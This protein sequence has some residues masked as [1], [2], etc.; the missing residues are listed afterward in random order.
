MEKIE[1]KWQIFYK[2]FAEKLSRPIKS[3]EFVIYF[4]IVILIVGALGIH[5][6]WM[7]DVF[8]TT[9]DGYIISNMTCYFLTLVATSSL[10]LFLMSH[11]IMTKTIR[12][13]SFGIVV[14]SVILFFFATKNE[15]YLLASIGI[16]ISLLTWWI[17]NADNQ[18]IIDDSYYGKVRESSNKLTKN[19]SE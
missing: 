11:D 14:I 12:I 3:P 6:A 7:S 19:W 16:A 5:C 15:S 8:P 2:Y 17:A 1:S 13:V 4:T 18:D 9:K 10:S